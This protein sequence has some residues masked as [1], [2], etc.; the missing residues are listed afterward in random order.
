MTD[1]YRN[2]YRIPSARAQWWD[3]SNLGIYF[4]TICAYKHDWLFGD[5]PGPAV[6]THGRK[7]LSPQ[8]E[9]PKLHESPIGAIIL[10][11]WH[12]SF[13]IRTEL[14]C[15]AFV[16]MPNHLH[17]ILRIE[18]TV[19]ETHGLATL[20]PVAKPITR[21][22][23]ATGIEYRPPKSISSFVAGFKSAATIKI[24]MLR[25]TPGILV[26]QPRFHDHIIR[27]MTEYQHIANY[28]ENNPANWSNDRF[29][30]R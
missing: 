22:N 24:N 30:T 8:A 23:P 17:A 26:W 4:I 21:Q 3:Y 25:N 19:V 1:K 14:F 6:E 28:I 7:S 12:K 16:L 20:Q 18:N 13:E 15:D 10:Q 2:K 9:Q 27:N 29:N 11:E 5:I